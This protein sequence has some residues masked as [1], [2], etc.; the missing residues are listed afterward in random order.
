M[1]YDSLF[2]PLR[3]RPEISFLTENLDVF[4]LLVEQPGQ[5]EQCRAERAYKHIRHGITAI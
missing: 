4:A 5:S 1:W 2:I 3:Y